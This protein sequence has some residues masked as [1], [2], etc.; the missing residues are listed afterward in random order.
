LDKE[1]PLRILRAE[2]GTHIWE[3]AVR[4]L[5]RSLAERIDGQKAA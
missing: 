3:P 4:A 5:L 2:S 1:R